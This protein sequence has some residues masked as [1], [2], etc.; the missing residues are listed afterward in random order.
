MDLSG[1]WILKGKD[2]AGNDISLPATVPGCV[3]IDLQR[4]GIIGGMFYR[5]NSKLVQQIEN[6]DFT[7]I[8]TFDIDE[9]EDN[10]Y[11]EFDGL[12]TYCDIFINENFV[13]HC[14]NMHL[15]YAFNVDGL[16]KKGENVLKVKFFSPIRAVEG[17][18]PLR[19]AFTTER[20]HTRRIQCTYSW[21]WVDRFVT[22]GIFHD[23]R[24]VFRKKNEID[25]FYLFTKDINPYSAQMQLNIKLRDFDESLEK[26]TFEI[27]T[28][29]NELC[30]RKS[31]ALVKENFVE[32]FDIIDAKLWYPNGYG[33]QP[34]YTLKI[35][36]PTSEK[37]FKNCYF[38]KETKINDKRKLYIINIISFYVIIKKRVRSC[39]LA[40]WQ[41]AMKNKLLQKYHI[42]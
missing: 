25:S 13:A 12:D 5:D 28:P 19:G 40:N 34:L 4:N 35:S 6:N 16:L 41:R 42:D 10:A 15:Y 22:M 39:M 11:L 3:H 36:T 26:L 7:Y 1:N 23:V 29:E 18:P 32:H 2:E 24:L 14:E 17:K 20:M 27:Y 38:E 30:Y 37:N 8:K 9:I 21:D 33:E 31:R